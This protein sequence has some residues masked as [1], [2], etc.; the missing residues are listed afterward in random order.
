[1][2]SF[3]ANTGDSVGPYRILARLGAGGM[4]EVYLAEDTR[5]G[6]KIALKLLSKS[7]TK[8]DELVRRFRLEAATAS[9]LNHPNILTIHEL[10]ESNSIHFMATEYIDGET[11]RDRLTRAPLSIR[12]V[13]NVGV[14]I[15]SALAVAHASGIIHRDIKPENIMLRRDGYI[16]VLDFGLAKLIEKD[17]QRRVSGSEGATR[18]LL[19]TTPG[20]IMGTVSYMSPEQTLGLDVDERTD[21]WSLGAV[22]YEMVAGRVPFGGATMS[23]VI[24]SIQD[25]QPPPLAHQGDALITELE[26]ITRKALAKDREARHKTADELLLDLRKLQ[27]DL[28]FRE[29]TRQASVE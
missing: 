15:A 8:D 19:K 25:E 2:T 6:R 14:Q 4:R 22:V 7:F 12:E 27:Q 24:V 3:L 16:K 29:R 10:G 23:H 5:L 18:I 13:T 20:M 26:R 28:D 17:S 9:S 1:M 21:I 11:L